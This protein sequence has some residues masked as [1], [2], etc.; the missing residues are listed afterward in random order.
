M[1]RVET[2][3]PICGIDHLL[4]A[5]NDLD[6]AAATYRRLGFTLS[7]RALHS[8][9]MGTAN[10]TIML[11]SDYLE[12]LG[13]LAPTQANARWRAALEDGDGLA[14]FAAAMPSAA[15]AGAAWRRAGFSTS[16]VISFSRTVERRGGIRTEARFEVVTMPAD[17]VPAMSIFACAHLT[18]D[19]V[20]LPELLNHAN[21]ARGIRKL[22]I[23]APDP[24]LVADHWSR[25]LPGATG[26]PIAG[27]VQLRIGS[28]LIDFVDPPS[29]TAGHGLAGGFERAKAFAVEVEVA[30]IVACREALRQS[31]LSPEQRGDLLLIGPEH[32]CGVGIAFAPAGTHRA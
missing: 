5:V 30:D 24:Q 26:A 27:G 14:G 15:T 19:A 11:E 23:A 21:S 4:I 29:A 28:H 22:S 13:V 20:W 17:A 12:L 32:A 18:R 8:A 9:H 10:H 1:T 6:L 25:A 7:P 31:G 16:D 3:E 2:E